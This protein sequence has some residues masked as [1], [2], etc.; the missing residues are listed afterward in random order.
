[1]K[2]NIFYSFLIG[3]CLASVASCDVNSWNDKLDDF[4]GDPAA[5]NKQ[6]IE[7]TLTDAD[8]ANLAANSDNIAKAGDALAKNLKA[9]GTQHYFTNEISAREYVPNFLS[10]PDFAYFTLSDGSSVKLTYK[11]ANEVPAD[12]TAFGTAQ[13]YT[14]T[15]SDYVI[16]WDDDVD[17]VESFTPKVSAAANVPYILSQN[18]AE[19]KQ[20]DIVVVNYNE[21]NYEPDFG[22]VTPPSPSYEM[23]SVLG[24]A[25]VGDD[26]TV[27]GLVAAIC[28][29]GFI[30]SDNSG[31]ILVYYSSG[32][33]ATAYSIGDQVSV[34]GSVSA[35]NKGL[36]IDGTAATVEVTG[37]QTM[38]YPTPTVFDGAAFDQAIT[39]TTD[40]MPMYIQF[41]S[42]VSISGNYYNF[43]VD[44]AE[45]AKGSL[46]MAT[47]A[48][49]AMFA[50]GTKYVITGYFSSIS[51]G[52]F[53]NLI[54]TN[55]T[56]AAAAPVLK[57]ASVEM[58]YEVVTAVYEFDGSK[59]KAKNSINILQNKDYED[60]GQKYKNLSDPDF[61][62]PIYLKGI[63]PYAKADDSILLAYKYYDSKNKVTSFVCD[64]YTYN[65]S[66]WIKDTGVVEE[67]A[68]FVKTGGKWMYDPNVTI[69]LPGGKGIEISTKY[70][71]ACVDWV[72]ENIDHPLGSESIK[73]GKFYITS[74]GNNEYY[75]GTSAYQGN[76]DLRATKAREQYPEGY[77]GKTDEE[78]VQLMKDRFTKEVMPGALGMLHSDATPI[79]GIDV[80]Y[81]V[82]FAVYDGSTSE[83]TARFKVVAPGTFEFIDCTWDSAE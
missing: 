5:T 49:K 52:R 33:D 55:A 3:A 51:G 4:E 81:T 18:F 20:G 58:D 31:S 47:D 42:T 60:M 14:V 30:L 37:N 21:A 12:V 75:S 38:E 56:V 70:Y 50:D 83:Y 43:I 69:T 22:G 9:V 64:K 48:Q 27:K 16:A 62:L 54:V 35:F 6:A 79:D 57:A 63:R 59:W 8:Y 32:F 71:Q 24:T 7:Y 78:V 46:Y 28:S 80:I 76:V 45:T 53:V 65:G 44:G 66:E 11:T 67:T 68:Q 25:S 72:Y 23:T 61:Y 41:T 10:D 34:S 39:R 26:V 29:R 77:E 73:S 13:E 82:N 74:Y 40:E 17:Y 15:E 1:M 36:Q 2:K 19:A